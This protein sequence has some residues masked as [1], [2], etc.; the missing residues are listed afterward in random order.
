M[1]EKIYDDFED[2]L[3][4]IRVGIYEEIKNMTP[5][6]EIAYFR[7][8]TEPIIKELGLEYST[9]QPVQPRKRER[10]AIF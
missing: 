3:D 6:E 2:E 1:T 5:E 10:V 9:L 8:E 4:A 7:R